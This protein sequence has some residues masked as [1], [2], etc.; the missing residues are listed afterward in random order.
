MQCVGKIQQRSKKSDM[1]VLCHTQRDTAT[2]GRHKDGRA[3]SVLTHVVGDFRA[4]T[5]GAEGDD[6]EK[7]QRKENS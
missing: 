3:G 7:L 4:N 2:S 6:R 1:H 5:E